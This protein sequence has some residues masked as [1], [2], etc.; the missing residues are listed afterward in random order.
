MQ[1]PRLSTHL[2][3]S[4]IPQGVHNMA[5]ITLA[6]SCFLLLTG[7]AQP[8][9]S[10]VLPYRF[11]GSSPALCSESDNPEPGIQGRRCNDDSG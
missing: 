1:T 6:C 7:I 9:H 10:E 2:L 4:L 5:R 8:V 11:D 3:R